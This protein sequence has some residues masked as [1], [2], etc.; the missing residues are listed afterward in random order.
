MNT[1]AFCFIWIMIH[2]FSLN[3]VEESQ[4][5]KF[6]RDVRVYI[7]AITIFFHTAVLRR[8]VLHTLLKVPWQNHLFSYKDNDQPAID[9][10]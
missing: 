5:V 4:P 7:S 1:F 2:F 10:I 9:Q 6:F 3:P 8:F